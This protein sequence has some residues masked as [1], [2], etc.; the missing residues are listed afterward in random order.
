LLFLRKATAP[1]T[2]ELRDSGGRRYTQKGRDLD[3]RITASGDN[4]LSMWITGFGHEA[5]EA[6]EWPSEKGKGPH[7]ARVIWYIDDVEVARLTGNS[8]EPAKHERFAHRLELA[9]PGVH[10][11]SAEVHILRPPITDRRGRKLPPTVQVL[12]SETLEV[13]VQYA[14]ADWMLENARD[15]SRNLVPGAW[16][17]AFASSSLNGR[18]PGLVTDNQQGTSWL[19][20]RDDPMPSLRLEF[21]EAVEANVIVVGHARQTPVVPGRWAR[22]L[23]VEIIINGDQHHRL[24][25]RADEQRKARLRLPKPVKIETL[26]LVIPMSAPGTNG[27]RAVGLAEVELQLR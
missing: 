22:A 21:D 26:E 25:M 24:R 4:P 14:C 11:V 8:D 20:A 12:S 27:E 5:L 3:V 23:E 1:L 16:P 10:G 2:G 13:R 7:V 6:Y 17:T 9:L 18:P 15:R 19:A